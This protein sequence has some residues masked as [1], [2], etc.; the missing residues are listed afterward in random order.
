MKPMPRHWPVLLSAA[1]L[2][3]A[4]AARAIVAGAEF[5]SVSL[6]V[7]GCIVLGFWMATEDDD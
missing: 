1:V 4:G 7:A 3:A 5:L 6:I 2:L